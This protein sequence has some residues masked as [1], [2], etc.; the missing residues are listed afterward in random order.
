MTTCWTCGNEV[1]AQCYSC[2]LCGALDGLAALVGSVNNDAT[3]DD[4]V[5]VQQEGFAKWQETADQGP[6]LAATVVE[7]AFAPAAWQIQQQTPALQRLDL[8]IRTP[9]E[10]RANELRLTA[11]ELSRRR[12]LEEAERL[13]RQTLD[14][15][16]LDYRTYIGLAWTLLE[17]NQFDAA[18][19]ILER[20]LSYAPAVDAQDASGIAHWKSYSLRLI[21]RILV[22]RSEYRLAADALEEAVDLSANYGEGWYDHAQ[23]CSLFE[24]QTGCIRSLT[25]AVKCQSL[26]WQLARR[27][28]AFASMAREVRKLLTKLQDELARELERSVEEFGPKVMAARQKAEG[29]GSLLRTLQSKSLGFRVIGKAR[30]MQKAAE[31]AVNDAEAANGVLD[32]ALRSKDYGQLRTA[33]STKT[34]FES[35]AVKAYQM[36]A[37]LAD[38]HLAGWKNGRRTEKIG[39]GVIAAV[40]VLVILGTF[41]AI[42]PSPAQQAPPSSSQ[43]PTPSKSDK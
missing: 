24:D 3:L 39:V 4:L 25:R 16:R 30:K 22:C 7:W 9:D 20:S 17:S 38:A 2:S 40:F 42:R 15:N 13:Y 26:Y 35:S 31:T 33:A 21:G 36:A 27:Q 12:V 37:P 23:Y 32:A 1:D 18:K 14:L 19:T 8:T 29:A 11:D 10:A 43:P 41:L 28:A 5:R 34:H 6:S